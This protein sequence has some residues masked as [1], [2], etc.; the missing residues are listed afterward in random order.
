MMMVVGGCVWEEARRQLQRLDDEASARELVLVIVPEG[1]VV[2]D[3]AVAIKSWRR[4]RWCGSGGEESK[5]DARPMLEMATPPR[6][7]LYQRF[8]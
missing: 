7:K 1:V 4:S 6:K 3:L 8:I 5:D 2:M